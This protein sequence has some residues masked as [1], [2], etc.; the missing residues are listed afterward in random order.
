MTIIKVH[1]E[2]TRIKH[3]Y[4]FHVIINVLHDII[5]KR[6]TKYIC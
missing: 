3:D 2:T 6:V 1:F 5:D 4:I